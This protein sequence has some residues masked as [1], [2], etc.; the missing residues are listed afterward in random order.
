MKFLLLY[1]FYINKFSFIFQKRKQED[2]K[3]TEISNNFVTMQQT[4]LKII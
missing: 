2:V 4:G 3:S 1:N